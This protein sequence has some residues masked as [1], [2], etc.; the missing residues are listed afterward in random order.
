[1]WGL[2]RFLAVC[3]SVCFPSK[4]KFENSGD[5]KTGQKKTITPCVAMTGHPSAGRR[6][7]PYSCKVPNITPIISLHYGL[8][9][10]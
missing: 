8:F 5:L 1:M 10:S 6:S 9:R 2:G 4:D 7:V 3:V